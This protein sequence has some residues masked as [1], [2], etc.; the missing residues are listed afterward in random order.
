MSGGQSVVHRE[1]PQRHGF[2]CNRKELTEV[3]VS[4]GFNIEHLGV[5]KKAGGKATSVRRN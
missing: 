1:G 2:Q 4:R 3:Y 5:R